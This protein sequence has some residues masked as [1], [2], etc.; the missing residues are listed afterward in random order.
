M[1]QFCDRWLTSIGCFQ[2][3]MQCDP[4]AGAGTLHH[5]QQRCFIA[6]CSR[7]S[8]HTE[9]NYTAPWDVTLLQMPCSTSSSLFLSCIWEAE[10]RR[11]C[12][13]K[14]SKYS[15]HRAKAVYHNPLVVISAWI[16]YALVPFTSNL[17]K[18]FS[19]HLLSF[20]ILALSEIES[21]VHLFVCD[22]PQVIFSCRT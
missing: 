1:Q 15:T 12:R 16:V 6:S 20:F 14:V 7:S 3:N 8:V 11:L 5:N 21:T 18:A 22:S 9:S 4:A 10:A 19:W 17:T 2:R 13:K